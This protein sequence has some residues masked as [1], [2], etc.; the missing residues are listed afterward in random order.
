MSFTN[1][2]GPGTYAYEQG[3]GENAEARQAAARA[4]C[5]GNDSRGGLLGRMAGAVRGGAVQDSA[6]TSGNAGSQAFQAMVAAQSSGESDFFSSPI[7][8]DWNWGE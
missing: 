3:L 5:R 6:P 2:W 1:D 7:H 8:Q 4:A